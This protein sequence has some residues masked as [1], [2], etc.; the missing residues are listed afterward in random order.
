[1][2][3]R[4]PQPCGL[5]EGNGSIAEQEVEEETYIARYIIAKQQTFARI[6]IIRFASLFKALIRHV[7]VPLR[8]VA[9]LEWHKSQAVRAHCHARPRE[10]LVPS[11]F[12]PSET[13][14]DSRSI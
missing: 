4:R 10:V 13:L 8:L 7:Q 9:R 5:I 12:D 14:F 1:L 2:R 3:S 6:H 11:S